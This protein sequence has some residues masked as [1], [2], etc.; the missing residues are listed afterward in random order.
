[1]LSEL[2]KELDQLNISV[3]KYAITGSGPLAVRN[4]REP[5]DL[6]IIVLP[7]VW[8]RYREIYPVSKGEF[9]T[10]EIGN[11]SILGEGSHFSNSNIYPL[12][13]QICEAEIINGH[14]YV[15]LEILKLLKRAL[16]REKDLRDIELIDKY[17]IQGDNL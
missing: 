12:E 13:K 14:P 3:G 2:L 17:L 7:K 16:G 9:E 15:R 1:M 8:D 4:L 6:D 10:V 11:I 5:H